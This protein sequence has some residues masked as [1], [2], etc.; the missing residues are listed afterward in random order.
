MIKKLSTAP[1]NAPDPGEPRLSEDRPAG[2]GPGDPAGVA[3]IGLGAI[4]PGE[5]PGVA[6]YWRLVRQ[7]RD[8]IS[9][10]PADHFLVDDYYDPDPKARDKTY[11]KRGS[12]IPKVAFSPLRYGITPKDMEATDTTQ[13]LGLV[14]AEEALA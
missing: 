8:A 7:G 13:L 6:G 12:F 1:S 11:A 2:P 3:V 14:A 9:D 10:I 4:F 5:E